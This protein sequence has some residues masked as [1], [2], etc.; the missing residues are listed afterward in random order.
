MLSQSPLI[1][2]LP[3]SLLLTLLWSLQMLLWDSFSPGWERVSWQLAHLFIKKVGK[4]VVFSRWI[5]E[6]H[7]PHIG[8]SISALCMCWISASRIPVCGGVLM[9]SKFNLPHSFITSGLVNKAVFGRTTPLSDFANM[10]HFHFLREKIL[11]R[12]WDDQKGTSSSLTMDKSY[13]Q[14]KILSLL[15]WP[16]EQ[17]GW[18]VNHGGFWLFVL[19]CF[20]YLKVVGSLPPK[21]LSGWGMW[22]DTY[23]RL[24]LCLGQYDACLGE[25]TR[26]AT[27]EK[28]ERISWFPVCS[29]QICVP[30]SRNSFWPC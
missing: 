25:V 3:L 12:M 10:L 18:V 4:C 27:S 30:S 19:F 29:F 11:E 5:I 24:M 9:V 26:L 16:E 23:R 13:H 6:E 7:W 14:T 28:G 17:N 20:S 22:R 8:F 1:I 15:C 21:K 2:Y